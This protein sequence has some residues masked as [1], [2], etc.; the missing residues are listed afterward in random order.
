M[1]ELL[2]IADQTSSLVVGQPGAG[3]SGATYEAARRLSEQG[4]DVICFAADRLDFTNHSQVQAELGLKHPLAEVIEA[5]DGNGKGVILIDALDAA[6]GAAAGEVI[7]ALIQKLKNG[8]RWNV[9]ASVRKWDLRYNPDLRET[10]R[11]SAE[12]HAPS[13]LI[14]PE[15]S[16]VTH[17]SI[18]MFSLEEL[19]RSALD[20]RLSGH[21]RESANRD[22]LELLRVPF[23]LRLAAELL[24]TGME[25]AEFSPLRDQVGLLEA[26][27]KRRV[28]VCSRWRQPGTGAAALPLGYGG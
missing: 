16:D 12:V 18:P 8:S 25:P 5:W 26:Y 21:L 23:N 14:D 22:T 27:W 11:S 3:K 6:R 19:D 1:T 17:L 2:K 9:V 4:R 20:L 7:L 24:D 28:A 10:F 15:F 13:E